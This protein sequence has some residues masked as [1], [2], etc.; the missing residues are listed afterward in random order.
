MNETTSLLLGTVF[1]V[2]GIVI[3]ITFAVLWA[4][5]WLIIFK[6]AGYTYPLLLGILM[7]IPFINIIIFL[8]FA[9]GEWTIL[10]RIQ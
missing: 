10:K 4:L 8:I 5:I 2:G 3:T 1:S 6:K 7:V 9:F